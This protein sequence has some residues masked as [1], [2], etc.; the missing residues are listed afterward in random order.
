MQCQRR[1]E[2]EILPLLNC[3]KQLSQMN[4]LL[5]TVARA[6]WATRGRF[7][8]AFDQ[9]RRSDHRHRAD[10]RALGPHGSTLRLAQDRPRH[11]VSGPETPG[12]LQRQEPVLPRQS[13][14]RA[15][16]QDRVHPPVPLGAGAAPPHPARLAQGRATPRLGQGRLL[17][18]TRT[19]Q[20]P[21]ALGADEHLQLPQ[22]DP[23][24]H[25]LLA[26]VRSLPRVL[27]EATRSPME[28]I[29]PCWNTSAPSS[30]ITSC[31]TASTSWI[32]SSSADAGSQKGSSLAYKITRIS[33]VPF[34]RRPD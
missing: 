21:R 22:P 29:S 7:A 27:R 17:R 20:R 26:G 10:R 1:V 6:P 31:S 11:G 30:G 34:V 3:I 18:A 33:L 16:L 19:D 12:R 15:H 4:C 14:S 9:A 32:E 5:F 25:R 23:G 8:C 28:S 24:I 2:C 13:G